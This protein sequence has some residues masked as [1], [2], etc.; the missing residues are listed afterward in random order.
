[1]AVPAKRSKAAKVARS[2]RKKTHPKM[3]TKIPAKTKPEK[4]PVEV[5]EVE[6]DEDEDV[7]VVEIDT[8]P[9]SEPK[10]RLELIRSRHNVMKK[11]IDQIRVA[12]E[13]D[14]DD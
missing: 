8:E 10:T 3:K 2:T 13:E 12:L 14:P 5:E 6:V 1:M 7:A 11:E 4:T 9:E